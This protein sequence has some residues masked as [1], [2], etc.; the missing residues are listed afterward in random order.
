MYFY[1]SYIDYFD[2]DSTLKTERALV[3]ANNYGEA[4]D[5]IEDYYGDCLIAFSICGTNC[6][7]VYPLNEDSFKWTAPQYKEKK[8]V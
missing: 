8:D 1:E 6:S 2:D 7:G 5:Y 4:G 3:M